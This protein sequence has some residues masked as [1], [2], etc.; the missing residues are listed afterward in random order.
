MAFTTLELQE[1]K[2]EIMSVLSK[3]KVQHWQGDIT[4]FATNTRPRELSIIEDGANFR[5]GAKDKN[6]VSIELKPSSHTHMKSDITDLGSTPVFG[7]ESVTF[8]DTSGAITSIIVPSTVSVADTDSIV[9]VTFGVDLVSFGFT[10]HSVSST[11]ADG[12]ILNY[13]TSSSPGA[14]DVKY[15][16]LQP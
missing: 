6:G 12:I 4:Q 9:S 10:L 16:V 15:C 5:L 8:A 2:D 7:E 14:I 11:T 3:T 13:S 1:I